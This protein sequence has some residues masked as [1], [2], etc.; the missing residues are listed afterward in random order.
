MKNKINLIIQKKLPSRNTLS[1]WINWLNNPKVSKFSSRGF[2]KHTIDSQKKFVKQKI[3]NKNCKLFL[4]KYLNIYI[5][6]IELINIEY[7]NK[8]CEI[9]YL[10]GNPSLWGKGLASKSIKLASEYAFKKLKLKTIY[11]DTHQDNLASQKVLKKNNFKIQGKIKKF[12]S[13]KAK[14]KDKI[15]FVK[16]KK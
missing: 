3:S 7:K 5:G 15:I 9:R 2:I 4:V 10:I 8:N 11:A 16:N 12:F 6:V 14:A 13:G 1:E